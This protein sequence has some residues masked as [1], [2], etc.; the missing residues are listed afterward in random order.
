MCSMLKQCVK[1][2]I[3]R[4]KQPESLS[5]KISKKKVSK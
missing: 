3:L 1:N 5:A 4:I 2:N